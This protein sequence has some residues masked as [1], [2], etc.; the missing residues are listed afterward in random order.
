LAKRKLTEE[1]RKL[2][3]DQQKFRREIDGDRIRERDREYRRLN[4]DKINE[5]LRRSYERD[6]ANEEKKWK[7]RESGKKSD[8]KQKIR[9]LD[10]IGGCHCSLCDCKDLDKL[11]VDHI[12]NSGSIDKQKGLRVIRAIATNKLSKEQLAN[13]RVLCWNHNLSRCREYLD[14]PYEKQTYGQRYAT[15]LW[16]EALNFFGPCHCKESELKFLTISH[17]K[18]DGAERRRNGEKV[19]AGLIVGFRKLGWPESLKEDFC[20]ECANCNC[21]RKENHPRLNQ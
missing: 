16:K 21:S 2:I 7:K 9:A 1:K 8:I 17:I 12:D 11:T 18:N 19:G 13:L 20:L 14:F 3:N 4:R 6:K 5:R 10:I 15:K